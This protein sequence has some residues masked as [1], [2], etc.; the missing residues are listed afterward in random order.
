V[1]AVLER[2]QPEPVE[3]LGQ[4]EAVDAAARVAARAAMVSR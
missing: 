1:A 4:L 2:H 3:S